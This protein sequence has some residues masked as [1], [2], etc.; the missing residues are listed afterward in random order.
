[1][2][3]GAHHDGTEA[4]MTPLEEAREVEVPI[5]PEEAL[6]ESTPV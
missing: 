1:M 6:V 3:P 4:D 2:V 5:V